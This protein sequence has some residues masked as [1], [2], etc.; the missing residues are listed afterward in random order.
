MLEAWIGLSWHFYN[1]PQER[2]DS[3]LQAYDSVKEDRERFY[4]IPGCWAQGEF[5]LDILWDIV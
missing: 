2:D 1:L 5:V 3:Y 4:V